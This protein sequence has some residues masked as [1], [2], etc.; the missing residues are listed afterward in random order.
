[1]KRNT[2]YT[3]LRVLAA[4]LSIAL[5]SI[6][7]LS[8]WLIGKS[9]AK[10]LQ[11]GELLNTAFAATGAQV[12]AYSIHNWSVLN[13]TFIDPAIVQS[14]AEQ[15]AGALKIQSPTVY[16]HADDTQRVYQLFG[17]WDAQTTVAVIVN[18][19]RQTQ[20]AWAQTSLVIRIEYEGNDSQGLQQ[21]ISRVR[22]AVNKTGA[23]PQISTC[24]KGFL[25]DRMDGMERDRL[26]SNTFQTVQASETE[27]MRT[28]MLTSVSGYSKLSDE[29]ITTNAKRMNMQMAVHYE[30]YQKKTQ[31]LIGSPILTIE[32]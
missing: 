16:Q 8:T 3:H 20:P 29:Y 31:V 6:I 13:D 27:A 24:I 25:N 5:I 23:K 22:A 18:S 1:M 19:M 30:T 7:S 32:Y 11:T 14:S 15:V 17:K 10:S 28:D 2:R 12:E 21:A 4:G 9:Y 26:I